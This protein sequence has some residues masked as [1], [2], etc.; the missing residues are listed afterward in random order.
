MFVLI[1]KC[2]QL[3]FFL[4]FC[5][6]GG[7]SI[8][9]TSHANSLTGDSF[10]HSLAAFPW[11][12]RTRALDF[13]CSLQVVSVL[14]SAGFLLANPYPHVGDLPAAMLG[15]FPLI[16]GNAIPHLFSSSHPLSPIAKVYLGLGIIIPLWTL[17][18]SS[19]GFFLF[20]L[21]CRDSANRRTLS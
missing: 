14:W 15:R 2:L 3:I 19:L 5:V 10:L 7:L 16:K 18:F 4:H 6:F 11:R 12:L 9:R 21:F 8:I 13:K 20:R 17:K 1:Y